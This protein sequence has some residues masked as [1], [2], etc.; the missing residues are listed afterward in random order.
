MS[1]VSDRQSSKD[2]PSTPVDGPYRRAAREY[3]RAGFEC[4]LPLPFGKKE[5]VPTGYTGRAGKTVTVPEIKGWMRTH[6]SGNIALRLTGG[7]IGLDVDAYGDKVGGK[8]L[9]DMV[10]A[11]GELPPTYVS[12]SRDDGR[13]GIRL[14]R[15]PEG[16]RVT[17]DV[18]ARIIERF[19]R[20]IEIGTKR[21][22]ISNIEIIREDHRYAVVW[23]SIHPDTGDEYGWEFDEAPLFDEVPMV[24]DIP[25]LPESWAVFLFG[26]APEVT[27]E[28]EADDDWEDDEADEDEFDTPE[29]GERAFDEITAQGII[30]RQLKELSGAPRSQIN[31]TL[32]S[33]AFYLFHFC[34]TFADEGWLCR[35]LIKAQEKAWIA[36][37]GE[38][39][40]D[41]TSAR[42][43]IKS[44]LRKARESWTAI[45]V[46]EG[47]ESPDP[48]EAIADDSGGGGGEARE[49]ERTSNKRQGIFFTDARFSELAADVLK[50]AGVLYCPE[51][52]WMRWSGVAWERTGDHDDTAMDVVRRWVLKRTK[53]AK[54]NLEKVGDG[55]AQDMPAS[56]VKR[57]E[58]LLEAWRTMCSRSKR[59]AVVAD[60]RHQVTVKAEIFDKD[61]D[62]INTPTGVVDLRTGELR[63]HD[64][65]LFMTK[66]TRAPYKGADHEHPMWTKAV[67]AVP[68]DCRDWVQMFMGQGCTG[69]LNTEGRLLLLDGDGENGKGVLT[70]EGAVWALGDYAVV[71]SESLLLANSGQHPTEKMALRGARLTLIDETP[72]ARRLDTQRLKKLLDQPVLAGARYLYKEEMRVELTHT[73]IVS[74]NYVPAVTEYD[75]GTWRRLVR[76]RMPMKFVA[77]SQLAPK[78][79]RL[80]TE[81]LG[82][83][84]LKMALKEDEDVQAA[85]LAWLVCGAMKWYA[86]GRCQPKGDEPARILADTKAWRADGDMVMNYFDEFLEHREGGHVVASEIYAHFVAW[87]ETQGHKPW[88]SNTF[89]K[90]FLQHDVI[91]GAKVA[92]AR[93]RRGSR[94]EPSHVP[95]R[96]GS[97]SAELPPQY[98]AYLHLVYRDGGT[99]PGSDDDVFDVT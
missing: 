36:S 86:S 29:T 84:E 89:D 2:L 43:T 93:I 82:D 96:W 57:L 28:D 5:P 76:L 31:D 73:M 19:G 58:D 85:C 78:G 66:C 94:G 87:A 97:N 7:I 18:E 51:M 50:E 69:M 39:D 60:A 12:T 63:D 30:R 64:R 88:S 62:L 47:D 95:D 22:R 44:A 98:T 71:L 75:H 70:N 49:E 26:D 23:P 1:S 32:N 79:R 27:D 3:R 20:W 53:I 14:F 83:P 37:G 25:E 65:T 81:R 33:V 48:L 92:K 90:R 54:D 46:D 80:P 67:E 6:G 40:K 16:V 8:V 10:D 9:A 15:L 56:E 42:K 77:A 52:G 45:L 4:P 34:P 74:T 91:K 11:L 13:S 72:E 38:D 17:K 99:G 35:E 24:R 41:Y 61:P 68:E 21:K 55:V 59:S